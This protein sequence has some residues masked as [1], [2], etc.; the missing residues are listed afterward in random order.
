[1]KYLNNNDQP[2]NEIKIYLKNKI[3]LLSR[4]SFEKLKTTKSVTSLISID[5]FSFYSRR[6]RYIRASDR[7][8]KRI[9]I[10]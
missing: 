5:T 7:Y 4:L 2:I 6:H 10:T 8:T 3:N 9:S 1:M